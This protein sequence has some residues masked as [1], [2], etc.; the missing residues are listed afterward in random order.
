MYYL[1]TGETP[2]LF[3]LFVCH[4]SKKNEMNNENIKIREYLRHNEYTFKSIQYDTIQEAIN[5][6][7][8]MVSMMDPTSNLVHRQSE[9]LRVLKNMA[10]DHNEMLVYFNGTKKDVEDFCYDVAIP[11]P[12]VI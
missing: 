10:E 6:V 11:N 5:L 1:E 12:T 3:F 9:I 2:K 8:Y 7:K 4:K